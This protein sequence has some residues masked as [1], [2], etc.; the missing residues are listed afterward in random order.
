M[1]ERPPYVVLS[2]KNF[3]TETFLGVYSYYINE[4]YIK[5]Q[6]LDGHEEVL[7]LTND[8]RAVWQPGLPDERPELPLGAT[9]LKS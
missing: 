5:M 8:F 1:D 4:G 9:C 7:S 2:R 3:P 6:F